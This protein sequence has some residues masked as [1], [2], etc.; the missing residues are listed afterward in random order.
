MLDVFLAHAPADREIAATIKARLARG[1]EANVWLDPCGRDTS[2]PMTAAWE[3]GLSSTAILLLL[4][5][6]TIPQRMPREA[7]ELLL[8][9]VKGNAEPPVGAILL[10][11]CP[12]PPLLERRHFFRWSDPATATLRQVERWIIGLHKDKQ[13][14]FLPAPLPWF[15]A[16]DQ[17]FDALWTG[18][19]DK[20]G[21][22]TF[23]G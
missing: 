12:Y 22:F 20:P 5:P 19:V 13:P 9:H 11:A 4:S 10:A 14:S 2:Q 7:W 17:D 16:R 8:D 21:V 6:E 18:L 15:Q 23:T 3:D 1:A